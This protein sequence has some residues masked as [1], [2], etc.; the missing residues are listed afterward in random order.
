M[1][2][3]ADTLGAAVA[4][5]LWRAAQEAL[6][7]VEKHAQAHSVRLALICERQMVILQVEDD[8]I[9]LPPGA[10]S[11]PMHFGLR[12]MRE[13][14]AGLGGSLSAASMEGEKSGTIIEM[15]LPV[16]H[17]IIHPAR[18]EMSDA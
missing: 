12:G 13:R 17:Q 15:R 2:E 1:D 7:N 14:A 10:E 8:G 5:I 11:Q 16:I 9:G 18:E 4:E 6:T 3:K